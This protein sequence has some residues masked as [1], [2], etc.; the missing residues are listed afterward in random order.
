MILARVSVR[1]LRLWSEMVDY[2]QIIEASLL[3]ELAARRIDLLVA[4]TPPTAA[5]AAALVGACRA[6]GVGIGLWPMLEDRDGR[7]PSAANAGRFAA[8]CRELLVSLRA[9]AALPDEIAID[10]EPPIGRVRALLTGS[11]RALFEL[12]SPDGM[13]ALGELVL[14]LRR[15]SLRVSAAVTPLT[16]LPSAL[17]SRGWQHLLGTPV[18]GLA[19]D[20]INAM[21]YTS[22]FE[23][24]SRGVLRRSDAQA[25]LRAIAPHLGAALGIARGHLARRGRGWRAGR[26][27]RLSRTARAGRGCGAGR[28]CR[29]RGGRPLRARRHPRPAPARDLARRAGGD[30]PRRDRPGI[31]SGTRDTAGARR[32]RGWICDWRGRGWRRA[33]GPRDQ[34]R[35]W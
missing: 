3:A 9:D 7:W 17:A 15:A 20:T 4:V 32:A 13:R 27:A 2:D 23:G 34:A 29:G 12:P 24:Y 11:P 10:L 33:A 35:G 22:L 8:F 6:A 21:A 5:G 19:F 30:R 14:E 18:D 16:V 31:T 25:V 26:R 1:R 28:C